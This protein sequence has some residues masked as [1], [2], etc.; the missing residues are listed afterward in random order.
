MSF[1]AV[2]N[3]TIIALVCLGAILIF[4]CAHVSQT[5]C[6][7]WSFIVKQAFKDAVDINI[8]SG[9]CIPHCDKIKETYPKVEEF[10][11][12]FN[13]S[14]G[15][16]TVNDILNLLSVYTEKYKKD[17]VYILLFRD[18]IETFSYVLSS[19]FTD[20]SV[21]LKGEDYQRVKTIL[22]AFKDGLKYVVD[23]CEKYNCDK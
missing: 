8:V 16:V 23:S 20:T 14:E 1:T 10:V 17:D 18:A 15:T 7:D 19:R 12:Y 3:L 4:G 5:T 13:S 9:K 2:R 11:N 21:K 22:N 6:E